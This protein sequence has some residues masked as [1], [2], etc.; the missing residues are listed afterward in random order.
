[1]SRERGDTA[2]EVV[3]RV[4]NAMER[5]QVL[6]T[7]GQSTLSHVAWRHR[8]DILAVLPIYWVTAPPTASVH[9]SVGGRE[10]AMAV[11][12]WTEAADLI[13]KGM[14]AAIEAKTVTYDLER[15]M[16]G[17]S[18]VSCSGFGDAIINKM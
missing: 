6:S 1:M 18:L 2:G 17:A 13:V 8:G 7:E 9:I 12:G 5:P 14:S 4:R 3:D 16:P 15:L 10:R 11:R